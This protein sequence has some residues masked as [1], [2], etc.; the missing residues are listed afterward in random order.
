LLRLWLRRAR[1]AKRVTRRRSYSANSTRSDWLTDSR[2]LAL[3]IERLL[4][5]RCRFFERIPDEFPLNVLLAVVID[6]LR[7]RIHF[8]GDAGQESA[9]NRAIHR[10]CRL[11]QVRRISRLTIQGTERTLAG[12]CARLPRSAGLPKSARLS[13][14]WRGRLAA[15]RI[16][17]RLIGGLPRSLTRCLRRS[18]GIG[19]CEARILRGV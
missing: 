12:K 3:G 8:A 1:L 7:G 10:A 9:E 18:V 16:L 6:L 17:S 5:I 15:R 19:W 4:H 13:G 14:R 11:L 2:L